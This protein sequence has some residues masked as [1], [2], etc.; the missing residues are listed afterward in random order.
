MNGKEILVDTNILIKLLS[1]DNIITSFLQCQLIFIF[2][3]TELEMY[4]LR[5]PTLEYIAQRKLLLSDCFVIPLN[6]NIQNHYIAIRQQTNIKL[7]DA[8]I[9]ATALSLNM[10]LISD[11]ATFT[12]VNRLNFIHYESN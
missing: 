2:F 9:A 1:G 8:I 12:S 7:A 5:N 3:I 4:G 11:D 10:P 6:G